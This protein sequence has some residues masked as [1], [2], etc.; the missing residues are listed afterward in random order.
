MDHSR[1]RG[2]PQFNASNLDS[3]TN[4]YRIEHAVKYKSTHMA[5]FHVGDMLG[6]TGSDATGA[7]N[8]TALHDREA[9]AA[10]TDVA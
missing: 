7:C 3:M 6:S 8:T 1:R 5:R 2:G 4:G 9:I 10:L